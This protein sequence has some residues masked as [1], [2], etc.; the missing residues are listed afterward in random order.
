MGLLG[1]IAKGASSVLAIA[2]RLI[3]LKSVAPVPVLV[4]K[5]WFPERNTVQEWNAGPNRCYYCLRFD[6]DHQEVTNPPCAR[7]RPGGVELA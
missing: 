7:K 5:H 3:G 6:R 4:P 1:D 2:A